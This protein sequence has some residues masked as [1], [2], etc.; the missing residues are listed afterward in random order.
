[1]MIIDKNIG[2]RSSKDKKARDASP[3]TSAKVKRF[4]LF[5]YVEEHKVFSL[6][7]H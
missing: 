4:N 3:G 5:R 7:Q 6:V 1:M 2:S